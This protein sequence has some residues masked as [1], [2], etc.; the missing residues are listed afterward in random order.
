MQIAI[1][2]LLPV[3]LFTLL[4][5]AGVSGDAA[6]SADGVNLLPVL[7]GNAGV[8]P[9]QLFWRYRS[10]AQKAVRDGDMKWLSI[11]GNGFL[12]D[13]AADPQERANLK[14]RRPEVYRRLAA[15]WAAWNTTM[16]P[17]APKAYTYDFPPEHL[18]D[19]FAPGAKP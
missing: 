8:A 3:A 4:A 1:R 13:L 6:Y 5:A 17:E 14:D 9:R 12:F 2:R 18:A 19:H 11:G 15:E 7:T 16:L 10:K